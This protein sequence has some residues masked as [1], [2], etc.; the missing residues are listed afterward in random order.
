MA[1]IGRI[2]PLQHFTASVLLLTM[3]NAVGFLQSPHRD[4]KAIVRE[5][6]SFFFF[7]LL[8]SR[9]QSHFFSGEIVEYSGGETSTLC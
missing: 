3:M 8:K 1:E 5:V 7:F 2:W 4:E 6:A 9:L